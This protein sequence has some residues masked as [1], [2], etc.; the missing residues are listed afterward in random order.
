MGAEMVVAHLLLAQPG[1]VEPWKVI[2]TRKAT[3][4]DFDAIEAKQ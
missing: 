4:A 2:L 1:D 3:Q